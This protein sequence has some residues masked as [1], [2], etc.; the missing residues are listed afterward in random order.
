VSIPTPFPLAGAPT[1]LQAMDRLGAHLGFAPG[2]LFVKRDDLT[3]LAGGGNKA[4]KLEYLVAEALRLG[5]DLLLTGGAPQSNHVRMTGAAARVAGLECTAVLGGSAPDRDEGNLVLDRLLGI[6][7]VWVG[8]YE[9]FHI[10]QVLAETAVRLR[11]EGRN[12]YE[13]PLGGASPVGTLGYVMAADELARQA[14]AGSLI[15]TATGTGGTQAGLV[16]GVGHHERVRGIDV[17]AIPDVGDRIE[18][19]IPAAASLAGRPSPQGHLQLDG[20]QIGK[21]YGARTDAAREAIELT[22]RLEGIVLD[23]VYSGKAMA[24]LIADCRAGRIGADH[25]EQPVVFL[26]TGGLPSLLTSRYANWLGD[27]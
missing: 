4:R 25:P 14:P 26:H 13:I 10:E 27:Q 8:E 12:P 15:Y 3:H 21:A 11:S 7:I 20:S 19:V 9:A 6:D 16:I 1:P 17:G 24:G 22:A 23:P 18:A 2:R 5:C